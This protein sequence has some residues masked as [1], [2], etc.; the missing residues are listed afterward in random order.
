MR[1]VSIELF[2]KRIGRR[3]IAGTTNKSWII[4]SI[5]TLF[6]GKSVRRPFSSRSFTITAVEEKAVTIPKKTDTLKANPKIEKIKKLI[7]LVIITC[8]IPMNSTLLLNLRIMS[9][10]I[11]NP[12]VNK[13]SEIPS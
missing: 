1:F 13:R 10:F 7:T 8:K 4:N 11:S 5:K 3:K 6:P 9:I 12:R 2:E